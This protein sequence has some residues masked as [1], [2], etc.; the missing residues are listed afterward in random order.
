[1]APAGKPG[2]QA[3][4]D[5]SKSWNR[6]SQPARHLLCCWPLRRLAEAQVAATGQAG[7]NNIQHASCLRSSAR[8][9][10]AAC[11]LPVEAGGG[12]VSSAAS[13]YNRA[14]LTPVSSSSCRPDCCQ[15]FCMGCWV[16]LPKCDLSAPTAS[17]IREP[18]DAPTRS[19]GISARASICSVC[20]DHEGS[21]SHVHCRWSQ[22]CLEGCACMLSG[23][24]SCQGKMRSQ[25]RPSAGKLHTPGQAS[26]PGQGRCPQSA[27]GRCLSRGCL[28]ARHGGLLH[29]ADHRPSST[30]SSIL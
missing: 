4:F 23:L 28:H 7:S 2:C 16:T 13:W 24:G 30:S 11:C 22:G 5:I 20:G 9:G 1:M 27:A 8:L 17:A 25:R 15:P 14:S 19:S 21:S 26:D 10:V 12:P 18:P 6:S 3:H 29:L